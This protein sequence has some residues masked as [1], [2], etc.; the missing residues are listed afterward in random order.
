MR[1]ARAGDRRSFARLVDRHQDVARRVAVGIVGSGA[2]ADD[3]VQ[4]AFVKAY[5]RLHQ[6]D[7]ARSF[8]PWLLAI[9]AN[10]SRNR[11]RSTG[12]RRAADLRLAS[13]T[14]TL[15]ERDQTDP[16]MDHERRA[17]RATLADAVAVLPERDREVLA[18][19]FF[20]DLSEAETAEALG[21]P[22]GTVKS[23]V[24]RALGRL[25]TVLSQEVLT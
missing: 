8:R 12:R 15:D 24:S 21:C 4:D 18:L 23:R 5:V 7:T 1:G 17:L 22:V 3:V 14:S 25:R 10:E 6:F 19:R 20:A 11:L 9:V 16:A 13:L 2:D